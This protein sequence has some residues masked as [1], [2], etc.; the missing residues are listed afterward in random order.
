MFFTRDDLLRG[1]QEIAGG[2][3]LVR[4]LVARLR[5]QLPVKAPA[6]GTAPAT[7]RAT[8]T[9]PREL[10]WLLARCPEE[11]EADEQA[12]LERLLQINEEVRTLHTLLQRFL[13]IVRERKAEQLSSWL[14]QAEQSAIPELKSFV[15]DIE[16]DRDAVGAALRHLQRRP[17]AGRLWKYN[18]QIDGGQ[19][20]H[21]K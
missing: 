4:A 13:Q 17:Q 20:M 15:V 5:K 8:P 6:K 14:S 10:R 19:T 18:L 9:S 2:D 12:D 1:L 7:I 16:C 11:L 21:P 3:S